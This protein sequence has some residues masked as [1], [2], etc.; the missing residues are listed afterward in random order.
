MKRR[1]FMKATASVA[2]TFAMPAIEPSLATRAQAADALLFTSPYME[3]QLSGAAPELLGFNVDGLGKG[4]RGANALSP[5]AT[6]SGF[7]VKAAGNGRARRFE[8]RRAGARGGP[9]EWVF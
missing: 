2:A 6:T 5:D 1:E 9:A 4:R 7:D 3:V 8:Y